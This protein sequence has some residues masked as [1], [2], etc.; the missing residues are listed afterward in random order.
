MKG[1]RRE[2]GGRG[3]GAARGD[4]RAREPIGLGD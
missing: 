1:L 2:R 3:R 4:G